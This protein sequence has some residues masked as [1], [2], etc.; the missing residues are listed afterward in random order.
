MTIHPWAIDARPAQGA[1]GVPGDVPAQPIP[2]TVLVT[3]ATGV[4][5]APELLAEDLKVSVGSE[6]PTLTALLL[7]AESW[8]EHFCQRSFLQKGLKLWLDFPPPVSYIELAYG[9]VSAIDVVEYYVDG[10]ET[11]STFAATNYIKDLVSSPARVVLS[12]VGSWP[13][14]LRPVNALSVAFTAGYG[15]AEAVPEPIRMAVRAIAR[16]A[17]LATGAQVDAKTFSMNDLVPKDALL[18]LQPYRVIRP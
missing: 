1:L 9:P 8:A 11:A 2:R 6:G 13:T 3:P 17:Y 5:V 15:A 14:G 10:S 16:E 18:W 4:L 7:S 12:S